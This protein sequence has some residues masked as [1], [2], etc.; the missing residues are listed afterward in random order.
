MS[1]L[2]VSNVYLHNNYKYMIYFLFCLKEFYCACNE[3][4]P[5]PVAARSKAWVC[6]LS[7][8]GIVGS[9][10]AEGMD[11]FLLRMLC[12]VR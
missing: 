8:A 6:V 9:N 5:V 11:V 3:Q 4:S 7:F 1:S 2:H 12:V 10:L